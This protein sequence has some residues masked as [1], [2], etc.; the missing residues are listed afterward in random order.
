M[1]VGRPKK[2][3]LYAVRKHDDGWIISARNVSILLCN[4][5]M[6]ALELSTTA[7]NILGHREVCGRRGGKQ[8]E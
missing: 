2:E 7:A 1:G 5:Y 6:E 8:L 4:S 3:C